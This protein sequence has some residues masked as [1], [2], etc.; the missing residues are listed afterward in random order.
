MA[1][2]GYAAPTVVV[3]H[4]DDPDVQSGAAFK[5]LGLQVAAGVPLRCGEGEDWSTVRFGLFGLDKLDDVD[6]TVARL[7][8]ALDQ[9][10]S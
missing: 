1:A 2:P 7:E 3:V 10:G 4:A 8:A 6:A 5:P 9:L